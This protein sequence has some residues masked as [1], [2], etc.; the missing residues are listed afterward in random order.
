MNN[1]DRPEHGLKSKT[2]KSV[3]RNKINE[4]L[5]SIED[6]DLRKVCRSEAIVTGG[7]IASMLLGEEVNDFYIYFRTKGT[8]ERVAKYYVDKFNASRE[9]QGGV[10]VP[11]YVEETTDSDGKT[12]R[13]SMPRT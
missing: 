12:R 8:V 6:E 9:K 7:C 1:H 13:K 11:M 2:I 10:P 5:E 4:W 3:L